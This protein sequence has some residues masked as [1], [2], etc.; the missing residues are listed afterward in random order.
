[1]FKKF[2]L[3]INGRTIVIICLLLIGIIGSVYYFDMQQKNACIILETFKKA[4]D[5]KAK[6]TKTRKEAQQ[7]LMQQDLFN[8][9][10]KSSLENNYCGVAATIHL[11]QFYLDVY[12]DQK[13]KEVRQRLIAFANTNN[14]EAIKAL[15]SVG[16]YKDNIT[17]FDDFNLTSEQLLRYCQIVFN[18]ENDKVKNIIKNKTSNLTLSDYINMR[19]AYVMIKEFYFNNRQVDKFVEFCESCNDQMEK[20]VCFLSYED[21]T[22]PTRY[23]VQLLADT[24]Y[25]K[26]NYV[27]ALPIYKQI[28]KYDNRGVIKTRLGDM[29]FRGEG[30]QKNYY[31]AIYWY[32]AALHE[33]TMQNTTVRGYILNNIGEAYE[34]LTYKMSIE[35]SEISEESVKGALQAFNYYRMAAILGHAKGQANLGHL[36]NIGRGVVQDDVQAYAW[37]TV[38]LSQG[39]DAIS[40]AIA[41]SDKDLIE[42]GLLLDG[43]LEE[44]KQLAKQYY[45]QYVL[46]IEPIKN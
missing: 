45:N 5:E 9:L 31:E 36:Y 10:E 7:L 41:K 35:G 28:A 39:M 19:T 21:T 24:Y 23:S 44:A 26:K 34:A 37:M 3:L 33:K 46:R 25:Q 1:M 15:C 13:V 8:K 6:I 18:T 38:A 12:L 30:T 2:C 22:N 4:V 42:Q 11:E 43:K 27:S 16:Y 17:N 14:Y 32:K 20:K 40:Q 29:Y